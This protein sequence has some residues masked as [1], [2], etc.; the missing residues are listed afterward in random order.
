MEML[1]GKHC[2]KACVPELRFITAEVAVPN[3]TAFIAALYSLYISMT[4]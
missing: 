4:L 1:T 3:G 2:S